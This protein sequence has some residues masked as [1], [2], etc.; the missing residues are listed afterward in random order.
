HKRANASHWLQRERFAFARPRG[1]RVSLWPQHAWEAEAAA[2]LQARYE[3]TVDLPVLARELGALLGAP[4]AD[5]A[6]E[7]VALRSHR[8]V[9]YVHARTASGEARE[10]VAEGYAH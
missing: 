10:L 3:A 7:T 8:F 2:R 9:V 5:L 6:T 1:C 4:A